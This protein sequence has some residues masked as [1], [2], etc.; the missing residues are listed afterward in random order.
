MR[1][2]SVV[3]FL[4]CAFALS[5]HAAITDTVPAPSFTISGTAGTDTVTISDG[6]GGTTTISSPTFESVTFANKTIVTFD[7]RGGGDM[8][9]FN[10]P[11]PA[12]GLKVLLVTNVGTVNQ[13]SALR[14]ASLGIDATGLVHLSYFTNDVDRVEIRARDTGIRYADRD[15]VIVGDVSAALNGLRTV[16]SGSISL[17]SIN[18]SITL[19]DQDAEEVIRAETG[20]VY[21][22][23]ATDIT[24]G[25]NRHAVVSTLYRIHMEAGRDI[26]LGTGDSSHANDVRAGATV[27]LAAVRNIR[28]AGQTTVVGN[29][30][31]FLQ[32]TLEIHASERIEQRDSAKFL[33]Q[34]DPA[35]I[36]FSTPALLLLGDVVGV[37]T[38]FGFVDIST[39]D[40]DISATSGI[41]APRDHVSIVSRGIRL[42]TFVDPLGFPAAISDEELD[43][44]TTPT[45]HIDGGALLEVT[46]PV[47]TDANLE[48]TTR[49]LLTAVHGSLSAPELQIARR[50]NEPAHWMIGPDSVQV[51]EG[52]PVPFTGVQTL[53]VVAES[54]AN[55]PEGDTMVVAP[56]AATKIV[57]HG[58]RAYPPVEPGDTLELDL[59]GVVDPVLTVEVQRSGNVIEGYKGTLTS[60][61]RKPVEFF[62]IDTFAGAP[63]DLRVTNTDGVAHVQPGAP[64]MYTIAVANASPVTVRRAAVVDIVP[65][66]L[67]DVRWTCKSSAGSSC[68]PMG[69]GDVRDVATLAAS[70]SVTYT[71]IGTAPANNVTLTNT[72]SVTP[73]ASFVETNAADNTATDV[74]V[75]S[76]SRKARAIRR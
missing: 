70:G 28:I 58:T 61:N 74:T 32:G 12:G 67:L 46:A 42:G 44:I 9:T 39:D 20:D 31:G 25:V 33:A 62:G 13:T 4:V 71:I 68:S 75:V 29:Q 57:I 7:G 3:L 56:S 6:P 69:R 73:P 40:V 49:G 51:G 41:A 19:S 48:L 24:I 60:K 22:N 45:I 15:D 43:R 16:D 55:T 23:A 36:A 18:G 10:N 21:L 54:F 38:P 26:L 65:P 64:V 50:V 17:R 52:D 66:E 63:V 27:V 47:T 37:E 11:N 59:R 14:Y 1:V 30:T 53:K 35:A 76:G 72:A 8:F 2:R 5:A 34:G